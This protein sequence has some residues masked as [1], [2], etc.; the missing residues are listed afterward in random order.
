MGA[1]LCCGPPDNTFVNSKSHNRRDFFKIKTTPI[2]AEYTFEK[3]LGLGSYGEVSLGRNKKT[4]VEVAIKKIP[5]D[6]RDKELIKMIMN[7]IEILI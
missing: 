1:I 4:G 2:T 5:I 3:Q 6:P 7:E